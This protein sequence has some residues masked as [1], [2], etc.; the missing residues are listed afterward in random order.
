MRKVIG[1]LAP[2]LLCLVLV[3]CLSMPSVAY[4][5]PTQP[6][7]N[8]QLDETN[9]AETE[10]IEG[11][12]PD[13][14]KSDDNKGDS[15]EE[16]SQAVDK[17]QSESTIEEP[18]KEDDKDKNE[19]NKEDTDE[20]LTDTSEE[21]ELLVEEPAEEEELLEDANHGK[22]GDNITWSYD[23]STYTLSF[24]GSG[25]MYDYS[26][27]NNQQAGDPSNSNAPWYNY[28]EVKI[29]SNTYRNINIEFS[30]DITYIGSMSFV[31]F[32]IHSMKLP[33]KLT[34]IGKYAFSNARVTTGKNNPLV[35]PSTVKKVDDYSFYGAS[36]SYIEFKP[37]VKE[38]GKNAFYRCDK[39][40]TVTIPASVEY[41][42]GQAFAAC[43][44]IESFEVSPDHKA[45][46]QINGV[47]I[48]RDGSRLLLCPRKLA[49][50]YRIP[51]GV[52]EISSSA[53]D[54]CRDDS[55]YLYDTI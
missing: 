30:D 42:H 47:V 16:S 5:A 51:D 27:G 11:Q 34:G 46:Q 40:K 39:L 31:K 37:G 48:S 18:A 20:N 26:Y 23:E 8:M 55:P 32:G 12:K 53:F 45:I 44:E 41:L 9:S 28:H 38:I 33:A 49:G 50:T 13:D 24:K 21:E 4:A 3:F 7:N 43:P 10:V 17:E 35:I 19:D 36:I 6:D 2:R 25:R 15:S 52:K 22:A 1:L 14:N 54:D 29:S